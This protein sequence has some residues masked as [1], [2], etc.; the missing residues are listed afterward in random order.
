[1]SCNICIENFNNSNRCHI[2]CEYCNYDE[3]CKSCWKQFLLTIPERARCMNDKCRK[4]WTYA[5]L[6]K[7]FDRTFV[8]KVY[9]SYIEDLIYNQEKSLL[10][11]TQLIIE[12]EH[13]KTEYI[14]E[15]KE[16][17]K[18]IDKIHN[19]IYDLTLNPKQ[20]RQTTFIKKCPKIGCNGFLSTGWKCGIC[21][22]NVCN[23]CYEILYDDE[24]KC[25]PANVETVK[26]LK[27]DSKNCPKCATVIFR[28]S[29]CDQM[30]CT[31]CNT[32]FDWKT[33]RIET[34]VIHNPHYFEWKRK[35]GTFNEEI[36]CGREIDHRFVINFNN[37]KARI[38]R[39]FEKNLP[40]LNTQL[41]KFSSVCESIYTMSINCIH[42]RNV[43]LR[44]L[45]NNLTSNN[46][47]LRLDFL[48]NLITEQ[49]FKQAV[50]KRDKKTLKNEEVCQILTMFVN[51]FT[52]IVYRTKGSIFNVHNNDL[53]IPTLI[54]I[55]DFINS[56]YNEIQNLLEYTNKCLYDL[57]NVYK[58]RVLFLDGRLN[59]S[60][61]RHR[62]H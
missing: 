7:Q 19:K 55:H 8:D 44:E 25:D 46:E 10:P 54:Q 35:Q 32:S 36:I 29:G 18:Q 26:L 11:D 47:D 24:H 39:F 50:Q 16:L 62:Y 61:D 43:V 9:K 33:L 48:R 12:S 40:E 28:I 17:Q 38:I 23:E 13:K 31:N 6:V 60:G 14:Q 58:C 5:N 1:M 30:F 57:S 45:N 15:I 34:G 22:T 52:D 2:K 42:L 21:K 53:N 20:K 27:N 37:T 56:L 51:A 59:F 3:A 49:K 41:Q 4:K